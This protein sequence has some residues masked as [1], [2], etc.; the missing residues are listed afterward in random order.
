[1]EP[2]LNGKPLSVD[3]DLERRLRRLTRRGFQSE[4]LRPWPASGVGDG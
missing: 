4:E 3:K 1:M 2:P